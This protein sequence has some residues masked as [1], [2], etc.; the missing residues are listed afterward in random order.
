MHST[1]K[2]SIHSTISGDLQYK[3]HT[4]IIAK[5]T[6]VTLNLRS[7]SQSCPTL[8]IIAAAHPSLPIPGRICN[9]SA[10]NVNAQ[11]NPHQA[12]GN[13]LSARQTSSGIYHLRSTPSITATRGCSGEEPA[14]PA[15][16]PSGVFAEEDGDGGAAALEGSNATFLASCAD[17]GKGA[18]GALGRARLSGVLVD[19]WGGGV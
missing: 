19:D 13:V 9:N 2:V 12:A 18:G 15:S 14:C 16:L 7:T 4:H 1:A 6:S 10:K 3:P 5:A 8:P 11:R 17:G